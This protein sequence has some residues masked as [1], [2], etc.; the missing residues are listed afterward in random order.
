MPAEVND[1][2]DAEAQYVLVIVVSVVKERDEVVS[3]DQA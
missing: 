3:L 2:A 1:D